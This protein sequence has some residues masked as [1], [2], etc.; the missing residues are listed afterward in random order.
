MTFS[1]YLPPSALATP[2]KAVPVLYWLSGLECTD[3]NFAQKAPNAFKTAAKLDIAIVLSDTSPRG[4]GCPGDKESWDFG[5]G[6]GFYVDA[7]TPSFDQ[8]YRMYSYITKELPLVV[9]AAAGGAVSAL[10]SIAGHSMGGY[11]G[12]VCEATACC[13]AGVLAGF[14]LSLLSLPVPLLSPLQFYSAISPLFP[15]PSHGAL[16]LY[17]RNPELYA[18]CSAFAP[19]AHPTKSAWG[20]KALTG[21]LG[22]DEAG[23]AVADATELVA[24]SKA[25][26]SKT[27]LIDQGSADR[28]LLN[29]QLLP[30][31]FLAAAKAAGQSVE[32]RLQDGY[33]HGYFFISTFIEDHIEFHAKALNGGKA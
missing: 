26:K 2:A 8:H 4:A 27:I 17:L 3:Q 12:C 33:D 22:A 31:D 13:A 7:T 19:I 1:L 15:P 25:D 23:W 32:Y 28:F 14:R 24:S 5:E 20:R 29:G 9:A 6:A 30:E 21:Y 16:T 18:S 11:V 10:K